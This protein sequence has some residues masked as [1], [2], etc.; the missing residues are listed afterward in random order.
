[1]LFLKWL[2]I[3]GYL[4]V[5]TAQAAVSV[6]D[7]EHQLITLEKP[8]KRI[9]SL[10]PDVTEILFAIGAGANVV[11]VIS[12]SDYPAA[13]KRLPVV[14]SY[15]G[16][17]K[18]RLLNLHPDLI[19]TWSHTFDR[20]LVTL[21]RMGIPV[22]VTEP[23]HLQDV[24]QTMR[25]LSVLTGHEK[26]GEQAANDYLAALLQLKKDYQATQPVS[27]F[28]Q[29]GDYS[30]FTVNQSSWISEAITLCGGRNVFAN[31]HAAA[32][33]VS[34]E[35]IVIANPQVI[36]SDSTQT[37]WRKRWTAWPNI[38]AVKQGRL[39][40]IE[41]DLLERASPRLLLGVKRLCEALQKSP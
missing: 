9:V 40:S 29:I 25:Q 2:F 18:E 15:A 35:A 10:A 27:V 13:A 33:E 32:P 34:W 37:N 3:V 16:I 31:A 6:R 12:G 39:F 22:Y 19:I 41:P 20:A 8:A 23:H 7:D 26:Q 30:L 1:M 36:V 11:G 17:D 14:G 5:N 28:Y 21:K 24:A 38:A 4:L